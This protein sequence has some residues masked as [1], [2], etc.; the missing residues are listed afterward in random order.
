MRYRLYRPDDVVQVV[1]VVG[2]AFPHVGPFTAEAWAKMEEHEH[3]TVVADDDGRIAGAIPFAIYNLLIRPGVA[4][5]AAF[6]HAVAVDEPYRNRG[7]G[8]AMFDCA[9]SELKSDCDGLFVYTGGEGHAPYTFYQRNGFV[10]LLYSR[11]YRLTELP[12]QMPAE[13]QVV[14][15]DPVAMGLAMNDVFQA[16]YAAYAGFPVRS[17]SYWQEVVQ[18][19]IYVEIPYD[20]RIAY[21]GEAGHMD[22]YV[23]FGLRPEHAMILEVAVRPQAAGAIESLLQAAAATATECSIKELRLFASAAHP[24]F[25]AL[26]KLGFQASGREA[27]VR[28]IAGQLLSF[29]A[30]WRRLGGEGSGLALHVWA[31]GQELDLPGK[32]PAL[33]LEMKRD[34]LHRLFLCRESV[35]AALASERITSP[36]PI[37]PLAQLENVFRPAPWVYHQIE[38]L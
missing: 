35:S 34:M 14:R 15:F 23:V 19:I 4:I 24:A 20:F 10:D 27:G 11:P 32:G 5:R 2:R 33:T 36:S 29:D 1:G 31:P 21:V 9:K 13:V 37:L 7:V 25:G 6:A 30:V 3:V 8:S 17:P 18:A 26:H 22:G 16:A 12:R 28:I 38:W